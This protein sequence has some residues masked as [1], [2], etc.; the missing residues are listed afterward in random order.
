MKKF[1]SNITLSSLLLLPVVAAAQ[2]SEGD[3]GDIGGFVGEIVSFIN[4]TL[5]PFV[6]AISLLLFIYGV[7]LYFFHDR[8]AEDNLKQGRQYMIWAVLAFVVMVS[9]W[10]IV[11][12]LA[13]GFGLE[14]GSI[15]SLLPDAGTTR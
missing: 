5:V 2:I 11:N 10:G 13:G 4:N 14:G 15:D 3:A 12:L 9:V 6:F 1:L 7:Y 8:S